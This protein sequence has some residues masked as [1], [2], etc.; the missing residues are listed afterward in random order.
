MDPA[1]AAEPQIKE[2]KSRA[3][4]FVACFAIVAGILL[5]FFRAWVWS[6]GLFTPKAFGYAVGAI[7]LPAVIA[8]AIAGRR[9]VRNFNRFAFIFGSLSI[10]FHLVSSATPRPSLKA[11]IGDLMKEVAGTKPAASNGTTDMDDLI[12]DFMREALD[13]RKTHDAEIARFEHELGQLYTAES[14]SS[15]ASIQRSQEAIRGTVAADQALTRRIADWPQ[16]MKMWADR[17][18]LSDSAKQEFLDGFGKAFAGSELLSVRKQATEVEDQWAEATD[19]LYNFALSN[20]TKLQIEGSKIIINDRK[21]RTEFNQKLER[22]QS[23]HKNLE[24]LNTRLEQLQRAALQQS[25][26]TE[27]DLGLEGGS[28]K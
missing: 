16:K 23:I 7:L 25:G 10:F 11:H 24:A 27:K 22:S 6:Y 26:L 12:R 17:S 9:K 13:A 4:F 5:A 14:F 2:P 15:K 1:P 8:Y 20:T 21:T 18:S 19:D 28:Q 3:L